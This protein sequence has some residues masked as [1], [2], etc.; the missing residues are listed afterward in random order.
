VQSE[1]GASRVFVLDGGF[2]QMDGKRLT[3]LTEKAME[4]SGIDAA[5][6]EREL[7]DANAK[8]LAGGEG[9][10]SLD[11]RAALERAQRLARAKIAAAQMTRK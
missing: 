1:G 11:Q 8:V 9:A 2:A 6:A 7:A 3:L 10:M 5:A 4:G